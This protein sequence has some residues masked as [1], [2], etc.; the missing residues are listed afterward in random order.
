MMRTMMLFFNVARQKLLRLLFPSGRNIRTRFYSMAIL[1]I[2][3]A[4]CCWLFI[5][6]DS[7]DYYVPEAPDVPVPLVWN[8]PVWHVQGTVL[9]QDTVERTLECAPTSPICNATRCSR[10]E[11]REPIHFDSLQLETTLDLLSDSKAWTV[12]KS[13]DF[14]ARFTIEFQRYD[15]DGGASDDTSEQH[16]STQFLSGAHR[17]GAIRWSWTYSQRQ[18]RRR[19]KVHALTLCY[20]FESE[21][22]G[23][24][25]FSGTTIRAAIKDDS[26]PLLDRQQQQQQLEQQKLPTSE[27]KH[28]LTVIAPAGGE[29]G[30]LHIPLLTVY[31]Y[32]FLEQQLGADNFELI[33]V[34]HVS[35]FKNRRERER[36]RESIDSLFS[37]SNR[38]IPS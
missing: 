21:W 25:R 23:S 24:V 27:R 2:V 37:L 36:E 28:H 35:G 1:L 30:D 38:P 15:D 17:S 12:G 14:G 5:W 9:V 10:F 29:R 8:S 26:I 3:F 16:R 7:E 19:P 11:L 6:H 13:S 33:I 4:L 18:Q 34:R 20:V 32:S 31:L 22:R